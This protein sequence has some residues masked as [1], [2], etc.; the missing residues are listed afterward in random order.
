MMKK[1]E[2]ARPEAR[3]VPL[4][5]SYGVRRRIHEGNDVTELAKKAKV[6]WG[7]E[8]RSAERKF[9][10]G[11]RIAKEQKKTYRA[12]ILNPVPHSMYIKNRDGETV[13]SGSGE[14]QFGYIIFTGSGFLESVQR[15]FEEA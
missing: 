12:V 10:V 5:R 1:D 2:Q 15:E 4:Y 8:P 7:F 3:D 11:D 13:A 6:V 14:G 9:V